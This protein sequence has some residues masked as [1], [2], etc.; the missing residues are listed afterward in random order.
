MKTIVSVR[1]SDVITDRAR[2]PISRYVTTLI[3]IPGGASVARPSFTTTTQYAACPCQDDLAEGVPDYAGQ[4]TT[5]WAV[6]RMTDI[7][8]IAR[9]EQKIRD[10]INAPRRHAALFKDRTEFSKLCSCL[11]VIVDTELA[12]SAYD[13]IQDSAPRGSSVRPAT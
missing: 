12:F 5:C 13:S 3:G 6:E 10:C 2:T 4:Q 11:D 8:A 7:S 1:K 9:W